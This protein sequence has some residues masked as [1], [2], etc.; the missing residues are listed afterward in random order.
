MA[1]TPRVLPCAL[2]MVTLALPKVEGT[3][4]AFDVVRDL[5]VSKNHLRKDIQYFLHYNDTYLF[6]RERF[7]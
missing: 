6:G 2:K 1:A 5:L 3:P 7:T 4:S